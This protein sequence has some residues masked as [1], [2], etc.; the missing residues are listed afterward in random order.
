MSQGESDFKSDESDYEIEKDNEFSDGDKY[1]DTESNVWDMVCLHN[2]LMTFEHIYRNNARMDREAMFG[3]DSPTRFNFD[4][5][6]SQIAQIRADN[7]RMGSEITL[8]RE[9]INRLLERFTASS[10]SSSEEEVRPTSSSSSEEEVSPTSPSSSEEVSATSSSSFEE[11]SPTSSSSSGEVS[12]TSSSSSSSSSS[13][14]FH[15]N[16]IH[17]D[18]YDFGAVGEQD[19]CQINEEAVTTSSSSSSDSDNKE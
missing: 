5:L 17:L 16:G 15:L 14:T 1:G 8:I 12:A 9:Q 13:V 6:G 18:S 19:G 2:G 11:V 3:E 4:T 10:S 7:E